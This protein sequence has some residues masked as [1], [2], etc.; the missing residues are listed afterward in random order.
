MTCVHHHGA[1]LL[2]TLAFMGPGAEV[3]SFSKP[4]QT[5]EDG[6]Y[7]LDFLKKETNSIGRF[8]FVDTGYCHMIFP[9]DALSA[10]VTLWSKVGHNHILNFLKYNPLIRRNRKRLAEAVRLFKLGG[11]L[12]V[13]EVVNF[14]FIPKAGGFE[15]L[16][17]RLQYP[18]STN[19][20]YL[21]NMFYLLAATGNAGQLSTLHDT[22]KAHRASIVDST[23]VE[24]RATSLERGD[25]P[26]SAF[27]QSQRHIQGL[28]VTRA[29]V[30]AGLGRAA[31]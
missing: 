11:A 30:L 22:L 7:Q 14:D 19:E 20:D 6:T 3:W 29:E 21:D 8:T 25:L 17:G 5:A 31:R 9:P 12:Q 28:N 13:N 24:A 18:Y 1:L 4:R 23:G 26:K 10:T 16:P 15:A 27:A 2:T